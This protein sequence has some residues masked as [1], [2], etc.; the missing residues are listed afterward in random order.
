ML[1]AAAGVI[2]L[3]FRLAAVMNLHILL[4]V[5]GRGR[6]VIGIFFRLSAAIDF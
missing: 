3:F 6:G 2:G 4:L 1:S 5:F